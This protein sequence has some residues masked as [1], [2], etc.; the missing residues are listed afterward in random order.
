MKGAYMKRLFT[1][2]LL[3]FFSL[4]FYNS[5]AQNNWTE[6]A[7]P[8][9]GSV[10][11]LQY[12]SSGNTL[13]ALMNGVIYR[14]TNNGTEWTRFSQNSLPFIHS[15]LVEGN[16]FFLGVYNGIYLSENNGTNW[17][18]IANYDFEVPE[19]LFR[20]PQGNVLVIAGNVGIYVSTNDG[21]NWNTIYEN[22][23]NNW[24][25]SFSNV[26]HTSFNNS[27][28]LY[29]VN[30]SSGI[31]RHKFP[32]TGQSW[33]SDNWESIFSRQFI[34]GNFD[35]GMSIVVAPTDKI[36][37]TFRDAAGN[38]R[39]SA[40][41]TGNAGSFSAY[42][43]APA[44]PNFNEPRWAKVDNKLYLN[45]NGLGSQVYEII[46]GASPVWSTRGK[47][48][49]SDHGYF[50]AQMVWKS[51]TE[52]F[53]AT[54]QDGVYHT[55]NSG[56][57]W[58]KANGS[59]PNALLNVDA[60]QIL[61]APTGTL[62]HIT[63][64]DPRGYWYSNNQGA[65]WQWNY[66][67]VNNEDIPIQSRMIK[68]QDGSLLYSTGNKIV[69]S[70]DGINWS[71][72]SENSF[73]R[74]GT[75]GSN[76]IYGIKHPGVLARS[77]NLGV[78]W[79]E[80][81]VS[82][83]PGNISF[84]D[85]VRHQM[86]VDVSNVIYL[87]CWNN[88]IGNQQV[89][90]LTPVG[91]DF[92]A[93]EII[94][95]TDNTA[96]T[97]IFVVNGVL[98]LSNYDAVFYSSNQGSTWS[99]LSR[100]NERVLPINQ[101]AGGI[102]VSQRGTLSITQDQGKTWKN[103]QL[104]SNF[105]QILIS[106]IIQ[107]PANSNEFIASTY[108]GPAVKFSG[109]LVVPV[110][111]LPTFIDFNWQP[112]AGPTG[113]DINRIYKSS[114]NTLYAY[115]QY[116]GLFRYNTVNQNWERL[117][118]PFTDIH[119]AF[120][121]SQSSTVYTSQYNQFY[122]STNNGSSFEWVSGG[123]YNGARNMYISANGSILIMA[124]DGLFRS[125]NEGVSF[126]KIFDNAGGWFRDMTQASNGDLYL[127]L[128]RNTGN[129]E[130][131]R[132][133]DDGITWNTSQNGLDLSGIGH[134]RVNAMTDGS[135]IAISNKNIYRTTD[136]GANWTSIR[137]NLPGD[138]FWSGESNAYQSPQGEYLLAWNR[139]LYASSDQ[140][141][142]WSE[143]QV[144]E[145]FISI[146]DLKWVDSKMYAASVWG[147]QGIYSSTNNGST[148]TS[149]NAGLTSFQYNSS[150]IQK[151]NNKLLIAADGRAFSSDDEGNSWTA[152]QNV[153][154]EFM[155]KSPNGNLI[156]HGGT[157]F[158]SADGGNSWNRVEG[159]QHE[160]TYHR[161]MTT[162]DGNTYF[163][164]FDLDQQRLM[165]ST[166]LVNWTI[167]QANGLPQ[168]INV[169]SLAADLDGAVY[170]SFWSGSRYEVHR[171]AF[172]TSTQISQVNDPRTVLYRNNKIYILDYH[173][174]IWESSDGLNWSSKSITVGGEVLAIAENGY[175]FYS[176][177]DNKL[178][179]SRDEGINWQDVSPSFNGRFSSVIVDGSNGRAYGLVNGR[180]AHRSG[181][182][183]IPND[184]TAPVATAYSPTHN[185]PSVARDNLV[186]SISF[187]KTV[188]PNSN[189]KFLRIFNVNSPATAVQTINVTNAVRDGN[190]MR[191]A[192]STPLNYGTTY[193]VTIDNEAFEDIFGN[194]YSG[195]I[196]NTTWRF[197][198][199]EEPDT[200]APSIS[201]TPLNRNQGSSSVQMQLVATDNKSIN[202]ASATIRYRGINA[203]SSQVFLSAPLV[204]I[205]GQ[206][207]TSVTFNVNALD[208]WY[209]QM[210][211]EFYCEVEDQ[212]G[213]KARSPE[214]SS[215]YHYSYIN[216]PTGNALQIP[217]SALGVGGQATS[218]KIVAVPHEMPSRTVATVFGALGQP[219][220]TKW[221]LGTYVG[222]TS[223]WSEYDGTS[224]GLQNINKGVGYWINMREQTNVLIDGAQ[225]PAHN[226][227][228]LF[229]MTLRPGWN[230]IGNPYTVAI[231]WEEVRQ[232]A[233]NTSIGQ[234]KRYSAGNYTNVTGDLLPFEGGFVFLQGNNTI[235]V[236]IIFKG[237]A[238]GGRL[239]NIENIGLDG[240]S[241]L[242]PI[243]LSQA[244][245]SSTLSGI[246]MHPDA[247]AG[248]DYW[249]DLN[250]P[251]FPGIPMAEMVFNSVDEIHS[252][253]RSVV[254][255]KHEHTWEFG[256]NSNNNTP[257]TLQWPAN[258]YESENELFLLDRNQ[259]RLIDMKAVSMYNFNPLVSNQFKIF[260]GRNLNISPER[261]HI[262]NPYPNPVHSNTLKVMVSAPVQG[263][264]VKLDLFDA[265]GKPVASMHQALHEK[266]FM[267]T[268]WDLTGLDLRN[269][270]YI[271][272]IS[273][274][275]QDAYFNSKG[276]II[277]NR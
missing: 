45:V 35:D 179:L 107:N 250:L 81:N 9:G 240:E 182:I 247:S 17:T 215:A 192:L 242:V 201:F 108:A 76:E 188:V 227:N 8:L 165:S 74:L 47:V 25:E 189:N 183:I 157:R 158:L 222:G 73:D 12:I 87:T 212:A 234:L 85:K 70:T 112:T 20:L 203:S 125:T 246:G 265:M 93:S 63:R 253:S 169:T 4:A 137:S 6:L 62:L 21:L 43:N 244:E 51:A 147:R 251:A 56:S 114:N 90:R 219:D 195:I 23:R 15:F 18:R 116:V 229:T 68:L 60:E 220:K 256:I 92:A 194:K 191:F 34:S 155:L 224:S 233:G 208:T 77:T 276:K 119:A 148:F 111:E 143:R 104:P 237:M 142:S 64:G 272:Q 177:N 118:L 138:D 42:P 236:P 134:I 78:S 130:M 16:K 252:M 162:A 225:T 211:L 82:G 122:K 218:Y 36:I 164:V 84:W 106:D 154:G 268:N 57:T 213:N 238:S 230:Q 61:A 120:A 121:G 249:D 241:W 33:S 44:N 243:Q 178:W 59:N 149:E 187:N 209:D 152:I 38:Y 129:W 168:H 223:K 52:G 98:Y 139:G 235:D 40:S 67:K 163:A 153:G 128:F 156:V 124:D 11:Q 277:I 3:L 151:V 145:E 170:M 102:A 72:Q 46:D 30:R 58:S 123:Q 264:Q 49:A 193:F 231:S 26:S 99:T 200:Q 255:T 216:F 270:I 150:A 221:R 88:D 159:G 96:Y 32:G 14:S 261:L 113:G 217:N 202:T 260:F 94:P 160:W 2:Y 50:T 258:L 95:P 172:G 259:Q 66:P 27:G 271:Y 207:T 28:D 19:R 105:P 141:A 144:Q 86:F 132:S 54:D 206:G 79:T 75:Y 210:G 228:T 248:L 166:D 184:G 232:A 175:F 37:I 48:N 136:N 55:V 39:I 269:G 254:R 214:S 190:T 53:A 22:N 5:R 167:V 115:R 1:T 133:S 100:A 245:F 185:S 275:N 31:L 186:L 273:G 180:V 110:N 24:W 140:G 205:S 197:T 97:G 262:S 198:I 176:T 71:L 10:H 263:G 101:G 65:S 83:L 117:N 181:N 131:L 173:G 69:R 103:T 29:I 109:Q 146:A 171:I 135:V 91:N 257:V 41:S 174:K 7:G 274:S 80:I 127:S 199:E 226:R 204:A 161:H 126:S 266:G 13:Y 239:D 267:E 89:Y 196:A